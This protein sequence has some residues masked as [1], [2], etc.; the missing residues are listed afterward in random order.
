METTGEVVVSELTHAS[1]LIREIKISKEV[2]ALIMRSVTF[3]YEH[4]IRNIFC[5][6]RSLFKFKSPWSCILP[7]S[8]YSIP[9]RLLAYRFMLYLFLTVTG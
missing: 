1:K 7:P 6:Y 2:N 8:C 3:E 4:K 5:S 9:D